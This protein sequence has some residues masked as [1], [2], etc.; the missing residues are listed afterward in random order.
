MITI[1][2]QQKYDEICEQALLLREQLKVEAE[3]VAAWDIPVRGVAAVGDTINARRMTNIDE[4]IHN[5]T[6]LSLRSGQ[7]SHEVVRVPGLIATSNANLAL[8]NKING[9]KTSL[10]DLLKPLSEYERNQFHKR[11]RGFSSNQVLRRYEIVSNPIR[12]KFQ[13]FV[14]TSSNRITASDLRLSALKELI[15]LTGDECLQFNSLPFYIE[16]TKEYR[17]KKLIIDTAN[18]PDNEVIVEKRPAQPQVRCYIRTE[19]E[20]YYSSVSLPIFM[21][22]NAESPIVEQDIENFERKIRK[23]SMR[24]RYEDEPLVP[25]TN[26]YRYKESY[27]EYTD[28]LVKENNRFKRKRVIAFDAMGS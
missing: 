26:I 18:I 7:D 3:L 15:G 22:Q 17:L 9:L 14:G 10:A 8:I 25:M 24:S 1:D 5:A 28:N 4:V 27:R 11:Q 12:M 13:W 19:D 21:D 20:K 23:K 2:A 16:G 6:E